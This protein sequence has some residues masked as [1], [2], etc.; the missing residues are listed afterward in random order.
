MSSKRGRDR[1]SEAIIL[2]AKTSG[3]DDLWVDF[4]TPDQGRL[5]GI[6]RHGR[7]SKKRFGTVLETGNLVTLRYRDAGQMV[8]LNEAVMIRPWRHIDTDWERLTTLF[9]L[10]ELIRQLIPERN[11]EEKTY[12]LLRQTIEHLEAP[13]VSTTELILRFEYRLLQLCG[14]RPELKKCLECDV[15]E[16]QFH[17]VYAEGGIYCA[18]CLPGGKSSDPWI[19]ENYSYIF[20]R[21]IEY[22]LGH[23]LRTHRFLG[24]FGMWKSRADMKD[25]SQWLDQQRKPRF[26]R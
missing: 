7:K 17:F 10:V 24:T 23:P 13:T 1:T 21:F 12:Q 15:V 4:L 6:A 26:V 19:R 25:V 14:Y 18:S 9:H 3:E 11:P 20:S 5:H 8:S 16:G 22:Q 2:R